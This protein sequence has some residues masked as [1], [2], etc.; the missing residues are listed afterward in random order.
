MTNIYSNL[1][2]IRMQLMIAR[3]GGF[4]MMLS[5]E[6]IRMTFIPPNN[7]EAALVQA[8][9]GRLPIKKPLQMFANPELAAPSATEIMKDGSGFEPLL[10][11]K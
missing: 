9:H 3:L 6:R 4:V 2:V 8:Q 7:L 1:I 10:F 11:P 5:P